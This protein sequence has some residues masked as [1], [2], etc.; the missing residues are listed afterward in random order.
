[1]FSVTEVEAEVN[2]IFSLM[3][4]EKVSE[5]REK[6]AYEFSIFS[7]EDLTK[8]LIK[9]A[10]TKLEYTLPTDDYRVD[11]QYGQALFPQKAVNILNRADG[12]IVTDRVRIGFHKGL[13]LSEDLTFYVVNS[14]Y[15]LPSEISGKRYAM[16]HMEVEKTVQKPSDIFFDPEEFFCELYDLCYDVYPDKYNSAEGA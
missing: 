13:W 4:T 3:D 8:A 14:V 7:F 12:H 11:Y 2:R 16:E 9:N 10:C 5:V 6:Y 15:L 1:M